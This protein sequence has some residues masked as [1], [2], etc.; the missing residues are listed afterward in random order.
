MQLDC[1]RGGPVQ[2]A[3]GVDDLAAAVAEWEARG[4]GPFVARHH[5]EVARAI[6]FG[7]PGVFDHSS[8][9]GWQGHLM[10]ELV[11][12]HSPSGLAHV[13]LHHLAYF[14]ESFSDATV[15]LEAAGYPA[16]LVARAGST[17]FAFHDARPALGHYVE[18]YEDSERLR[19]FYAQVR[20]TAQNEPVSC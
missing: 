2:I 20:A 1:L 4:A 19:E 7:E 11:Q 9:Y 8:A 16:A 18:I 13:G 15:E 3:Y 17:D 14:V 10:V 5:I 12:V 6:V